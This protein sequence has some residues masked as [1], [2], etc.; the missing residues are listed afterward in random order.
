MVIVFVALAK[1]AEYQPLAAL[2]LAMFFI[3]ARQTPR[4]GKLAS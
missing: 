2:L 3:E 1:L 4:G